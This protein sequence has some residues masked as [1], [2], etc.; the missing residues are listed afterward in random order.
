M[1][2]GL[3]GRELQQSLKTSLP[4]SAYAPPGIIL[5]EKIR[6]R[7]SN[8]LETFA[9]LLSFAFFSSFLYAFRLLAGTLTFSFA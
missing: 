8:H 4:G 1:I 3:T 6:D 5:P 7:F 2:H 9:F